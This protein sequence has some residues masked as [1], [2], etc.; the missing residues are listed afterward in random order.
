MSSYFSF[1]VFVMFFCFQER[2]VF[3]VPGLEVFR[4]EVT[5]IFGRCTYVCVDVSSRRADVLEEALLQRS[6]KPVPSNCHIISN[7]M[8]FDE[9][10]GDQLVVSLV[11]LRISCWCCLLLSSF[12]VVTAAVVAVTTAV[13]AVD[14]D[15]MSSH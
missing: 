10:R 11:I 3:E 13:V 5:L 4:P 2:K 14:V 8:I 15:M 12:V 6:E 9:V 1:P 7:R